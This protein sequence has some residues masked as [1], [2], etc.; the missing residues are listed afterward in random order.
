MVMNFRARAAAY[1]AAPAPDGPRQASGPHFPRARSATR[2]S[3]PAG[4]H[5][6]TLARNH[7]KADALAQPLVG[8]GER[9]GEKP[10]E[11]GSSGS[12][13]HRLSFLPGSGA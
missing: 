4:H 6:R 9:G 2:R 11:S 1:G 12:S 13:D 3:E 10:V 7:G 8:N 5:R